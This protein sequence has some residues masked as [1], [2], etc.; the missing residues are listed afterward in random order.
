[1][2]VGERAQECPFTVRSSMHQYGDAA[3]F[4]LGMLNQIEVGPQTVFH[5]FA[6]LKWNSPLATLDTLQAIIKRG[7][8]LSF[9]RETMMVHP[10]H[11]V[12]FLSSPP[13]SRSKSESHRLLKAC[14]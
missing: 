9:A 12:S 3:C 1:M 2:R 4:E 14:P 7:M 13:Q 5:Y 6:G 8:P 10:L 11:R